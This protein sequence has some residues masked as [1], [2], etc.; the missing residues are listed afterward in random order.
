[1]MPSVVIDNSGEVAAGRSLLSSRCGPLRAAPCSIELPEM[2]DQQFSQDPD[3]SRRVVPRWSDNVD[4]DFG[5][6]IAIHQRY[7]S[8]GRQLFLR[9]EF[10]QRRYAS[11]FGCW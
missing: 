3:F 10:R 1:M 11:R 2:L 4:A 9:Q 7:Q 6:R 8:A 5:E